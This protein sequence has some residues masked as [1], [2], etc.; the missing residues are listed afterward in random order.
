MINGEKNHDG[1]S[2]ANEKVWDIRDIVWSKA[3]GSV[4]SDGVHMKSELSIDGVNHYLKLSRYDSYNGIYGHESV[5]ELIAARLGDL[6]GFPVPTGE[7]RKSLIRV[8]DTEHE[9]YVYMAKSYKTTGSRVAFNDFYVGYRLSGSESPL[10]LCKRFGW[11]EY[12]YKMFVFDY[13]IINRD[14]HGANLEVM[15]NG[16]KALSPLFDNGLS[17]V[18]SCMNEKQVASFTIMEDRPVNN[19]IGEKSLE[20]NLEKIDKK[21]GYNELKETDRVKIFERLHGVLPDS[22]FTAIW[23]IIWR[24]WQNVAQFRLA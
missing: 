20:A 1:E 17:F 7:L 4:E 23:Q 19:F 9:A 15:K 2:I 12:V 6:L 5:N 14:R 13:L 24:R 21:I 22:Y 3:A 8:D 18:C 11:T 10:D 16:E